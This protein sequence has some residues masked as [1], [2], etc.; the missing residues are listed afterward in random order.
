MKSNL[1]M[2]SQVLYTTMEAS[3]QEWDHPIKK[4]Y[5]LPYST[6]SN[7]F[8]IS[9]SKRMQDLSSEFATLLKNSIHIFD[10]WCHMVE[11]IAL[12]YDQCS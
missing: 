2:V 12:F 1:C 3:V 5:A 8:N 11:Y 10:T 6:Q 4:F 9:T 7:Y